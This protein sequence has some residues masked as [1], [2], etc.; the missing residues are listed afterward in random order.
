MNFGLLISFTVFPGAT[1]WCTFCAEYVKDL[2]SERT[3]SL[4][5]EILPRPLSPAFSKETFML[6]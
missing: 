1:F 5:Y 4:S 2:D 3:K 6:L